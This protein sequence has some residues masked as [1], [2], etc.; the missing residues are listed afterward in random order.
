MKTLTIILTLFLSLPV[1]AQVPEQAEDIS[2][3]LIGETIPDAMLLDSKGNQVSVNSLIKNKPTVL[4]FYRG[5]WCPYCNAQ[6]SALG[7][8][9]QEILDLG[10]QI[11]AVSP[12]HVESLQP[13]IEGERL[14]YGVFADPQAEFIQDVGIGFKTPEK[15]KGY[16]FKKTQKEA[17][18]IL[19]VPTVMI[20]DTKGKILYEYINPDYS[21][22]L[23]SELL[24]ANL[25]AL[26]KTL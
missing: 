23:S 19:P 21:T 11:I 2:P 22:R 9:E 26:K 20:V 12:D 4:V 5:G 7:E 16:I 24:L 15:A 17:S 25:I 14:S 3:L 8:S 10:F 1:L 6:L 18:D 13:T